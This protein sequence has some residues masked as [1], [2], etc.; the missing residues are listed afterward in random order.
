MNNQKYINQ[1]IS[2]LRRDDPYETKPWPS[3]YSFVFEE[4]GGK[5]FSYVHIHI[6]LCKNIPI[7]HI[8]A[9][10]ALGKSTKGTDN[11]S[12]IS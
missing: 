5:N 4:L 2:I 7:E 3:T 11:F 9:I 1:N 10:E 8:W 6:D 12:G